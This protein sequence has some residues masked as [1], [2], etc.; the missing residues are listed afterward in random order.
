M[1]FE[2]SRRWTRK[3]DDNEQHCPIPRE[4]HQ[5][6]HT[7]NNRKVLRMFILIAL[8]VLLACEVLD[9]MFAKKGSQLRGG[10]LLF[11]GDSSKTVWVPPNAA[12]FNI[13]GEA[14][15]ANHLIVVAGH[16]VIISGHLQ[17]A[18]IDENDWYLLA[19]QKGKGLPQAILKHI[20][21]GIHQASLDPQSLLIFSGGET[22]ATTGPVN[23]GTSYFQ[24]ADAMNLWEE[25]SSKPTSN[26]E[27][28]K[29][30][31]SRTLTEEFATDSYQNL[32]FSI[33]RFREVTGNY[34]EKITVVSFTF[35]KYR[36]EEL[37]ATKALRWPSSKF[38]YVGIDPDETTG[39]NLKE[40]KEGELQNA[41][42]PF[43]TDPYGCHS[44]VLIQK[45]KDRNPFARTPPYELT[46]PEIKTLLNWCGPDSIP[47]SNLP[48][49]K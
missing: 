22:R 5:H 32:L 11:S 49:R 6:I 17:D 16:S 27:T 26:G 14:N 10:S 29:S 40:S 30:V 33:C 45:R 36:F 15:L 2:L 12:S 9:K 41:A 38:I 1:A 3:G 19:Y 24:V 21:E 7:N 28:S 34:P 47:E 25:N 48:W 13:N 8:A 35:K 23:E 20:R 4:D 39:F 43:E 46:C 31:R 37:H 42:L 18:G 44:Q